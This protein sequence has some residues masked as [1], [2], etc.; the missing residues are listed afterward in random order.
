MTY[1]AHNFGMDPEKYETDK[2][3]KDMFEVTSISYLPTTGAPFVTSAESTKYPIMGTLFHPEKP[4]QIFSDGPGIDHSWQSIQ[5]QRHF[6]DYFVYLARHN[7]HSYGNFSAVQKDIIYNHKM[8]VSD[9]W[10][11]SAYV[12]E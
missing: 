1:N 3:L 10:Y 11:G 9:D 12:F 7:P 8:I 2:G 5:L 4:S 6:A